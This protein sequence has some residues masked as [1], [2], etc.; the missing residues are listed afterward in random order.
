MAHLSHAFSVYLV[1]NLVNGKLYVGCTRVSLKRRWSQHL[2]C[3]R[4]GSQLALHRA[5][6]KYTEQNFTIQCLEVLSTQAAMLEAEVS[7]IAAHH[8]MVP[9]GYNL[10]AGGE[11]V[12]FT[13]PEAREKMMRG[14]AR[15][16]ADPLWHVACRLG[17][18]RRSSNP[19]WHVA[20]R[21]GSKR[22]SSNPEWRM[23]TLKAARSRSLD[24][25]CRAS[26]KRGSQKRSACPEWQARNRAALGQSRAVRSAQAKIRDEHLP[27]EDRERRARV[28]EANRLSHAKTGPRL[29]STEAMAIARASKSEAVRLA[30]LSLSPAK[31]AQKARRREADRLRQAA[32]RQKCTESQ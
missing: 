1:T 29:S 20:C 28:R 9:E 22:R 11:G 10:T 32:K 25:V 19:L 30:D 3:A 16:K 31:A 14:A 5:L 15:R 23:N 24:P 21:L 4:K 7:Q 8:C 27:L 12:D 13:V 6:R 18:K 17:S 2:S 26:Q